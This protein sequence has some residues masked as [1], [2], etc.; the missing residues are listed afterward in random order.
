MT[1]SFRLRASGTASN[2]ASAVFSPR[3][4]GWFLRAAPGHYHRTPA[5]L[6]SDP[7]SDAASCVTL[8]QWLCLSESLSPEDQPRRVPCCPSE[9][10]GRGGLSREGGGAVLLVTVGAS[11]CQAPA[12]LGPALGDGQLGRRRFQ[13]EV[14][15]IVHAPWIPSCGQLAAGA[16]RGTRTGTGRS[17]SGLARAESLALESGGPPPARAP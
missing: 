15:F 12:L 4:V 6:G 16:A 14:M 1:F 2:Y 3:S 9:P 5:D 11:A 13:A 7:G 10:L 17:D 8:G